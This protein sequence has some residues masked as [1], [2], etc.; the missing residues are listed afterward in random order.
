M[1]GPQPFLYFSADPRLCA[2][3]DFKDVGDGYAVIQEQCFFGW[4]ISRRFPDQNVLDDRRGEFWSGLC[5][6]TIRRTD[7]H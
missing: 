7:A 5:E 6:E 2:K 3:P 4:V 1:V